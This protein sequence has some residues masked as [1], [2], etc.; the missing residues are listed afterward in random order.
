VK[1]VLFLIHALF[2][3]K[4]CGRSAVWLY[5]LDVLLGLLPFIAHGIDIEWPTTGHAEL[6]PDH[7][8]PFVGVLR[9]WRASFSTSTFSCPYV[10]V[11]P[12]P[13]K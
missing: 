5:E 7:D 6:D 8:Q 1:T 13:M 3:R 11:D 4:P 9:V 2:K 10:A 12:R